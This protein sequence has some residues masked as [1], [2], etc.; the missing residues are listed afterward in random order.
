MNDNDR[1]LLSIVIPVYNVESYLG[2]CVE[3]VKHQ[4]TEQCEIIMIDDGSTDTSGLLCDELSKDYCNIKTIHKE[5]GGLSDARN[6]GINNA[7]GKYIMFLDADDKLADKCIGYILEHISCC[8]TD[9]LLGRAMTFS[10]NN[11]EG[12]GC[13]NID[14]YSKYKSISEPASVFLKL[15]RNPHFWCAAWLLIIQKDFLVKNGLYFEKGIFHE[16][17]LWIPLV[18]V[19]A[20]SIFLFE[21]SFYMYRVNRKGSIVSSL[22]I[23]REFDKLRITDYLIKEESGSVYGDI[24]LK[25]RMAALVFGVILSLQSYRNDPLYGELLNEIQKKMHMLCYGK[26]IL[27]RLICVIM[28]IERCSNMMSKILT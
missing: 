20:T 19:K 16:D 3:S 11:I 14:S 9:I 26:Y 22:N 23:K 21:E 12:N 10:D 17:E 7:N 28:G 2:E 4:M 5:N 1:I 6:V 25:R 8:E 13:Y 15:D 27:I 18:A 24:L